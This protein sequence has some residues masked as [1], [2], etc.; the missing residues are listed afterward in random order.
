MKN[1]DFYNCKQSKE[2][3]Y[4]VIKNRNFIDA[5]IISLNNLNVEIEYDL[6]E[7]K[8][9]E[10][11]KHK[12]IMCINLIDSYIELS[13]CYEINLENNVYYDKYY[14]IKFKERKLK[15]SNIKFENLYLYINKIFKNKLK[16]CFSINQLKLEIIKNV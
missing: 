6:S 3:Y 15:K 5:H 10:T 7:M 13:S 11:L 14:T 16:Y 2:I 4:V 12:K 8:K 1:I 9:F